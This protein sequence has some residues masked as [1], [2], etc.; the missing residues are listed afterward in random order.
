MILLNYSAV[1]RHSRNWQGLIKETTHN[2]GFPSII[3]VRLG[4]I[5]KSEKRATFSPDHRIARE[6][7]GWIRIWEDVAWTRVLA[8]HHKHF[9]HSLYCTQVLYQRQGDIQRLPLIK[10]LHIIIYLY[11]QPI[12]RYVIAVS[13]ILPDE[14]LRGR[15]SMTF[16]YFVRRYC[17]SQANIRPLIPASETRSVSSP[18]TYFL[19]R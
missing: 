8:R 18:S 15:E 10:N 12:G 7:R 3:Q 1:S 6:A 4:S 9:A 16:Q 2:K 17:L 19:R 13:E 14:S 11:L 5:C